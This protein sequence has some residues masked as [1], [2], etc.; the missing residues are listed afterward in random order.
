VVRLLV[1]FYTHNYIHQSLSARGTCTYIRSCFFFL[2][3]SLIDEKTTIFPTKETCCSKRVHN[4]AKLKRNSRFHT[5]RRRRCRWRGG[6]R[7]KETMGNGRKNTK[8]RSVYHGQLNCLMEFRRRYCYSAAPEYM[9]VYLRVCERYI[10]RLFDA[11]GIPIPSNW[12]PGNSQYSPT[13]IF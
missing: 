6:G 10:P 7:T 1:H 11:I 4:I 9:C 8:K 13:F 3:P 2:L 5:G 12:N